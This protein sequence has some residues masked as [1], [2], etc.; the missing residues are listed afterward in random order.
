MAVFFWTLGMVSS[1]ARAAEGPAVTVPSAVAD[2]ADAREQALDRLRRKDFEAAFHAY[3]NLLREN[4]EDDEVNYGLAYA[5]LGSDRYPQALLAFER[6]S[7]RHPA[8]AELHVRLAEMHI[9]LRDADAARRELEAARRCNASVRADAAERALRGL[10]KSVSLWR[11]SG[12]LSAG[13]MYDSNA[14][15]GPASDYMTL[16]QWEN[17]YLKGVSGMASWGRYVSAGA[18]GARRLAEG[19]PWWLVGDAGFYKRWNGNPDLLTNREFGWGRLAL[20]VRYLGRRLMVEARVKEEMADQGQGQHIRSFGPELSAVWMPH[21]RV[22]FI[23]RAGLERRD[24]RHDRPHNGL[25][26]WAG[27]YVRFFVGEARH[28]IMAGARVLRGMPR[29]EAYAYTG[30]EGS[31]SLTFRLPHRLALS[32]SVSFRRELYRGPASGLETARRSDGALRYGLSLQYGLTRR[33]TAEAGWQCG[34]FTSSSALYR[35]T[36][37]TLTMGLTWMF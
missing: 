17:L 30:W 12:R 28:E 6:L 9:R 37:Q 13:V 21:D 3:M 10:E 23:S 11:W 25:Y 26:W 31:L 32:P 18:D 22:Q 27:P 14:N 35:Y 4:P 16:G 36:Q 19:T 33:L 8:D 24:Y 20:G 2:S 29:R 15:L 1:I 7:D 34:R 5:A